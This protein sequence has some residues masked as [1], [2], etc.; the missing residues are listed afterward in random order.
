MCQHNISANLK[1]NNVHVFYVQNTC[2]VK[3]SYM[4]IIPFT[5]KSVK[6]T[7]FC[8]HIYHTLSLYYL[9]LTKIYLINI[10]KYHRK[11]IKIALILVSNLANN[12]SPVSATIYKPFLYFGDNQCFFMVVS[13][14]EVKQLV[15]WYRGN[16]VVYDNVVLLHNCVWYNYHARP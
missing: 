5:C 11:Y 10:L 16:S 9:K 12:W 6:L 13:K 1:Y 3:C 4:Q 14:N 2:Y 8:V 15:G 7:L